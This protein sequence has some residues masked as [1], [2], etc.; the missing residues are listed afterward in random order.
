MRTVTSLTAVLLGFIL[1]APA[2]V[3]EDAKPDSNDLEV[4]QLQQP[5]GPE[6]SPAQ[7]YCS[8]IM[9]T[10]TAA[11]I[12]QQTRNLEAAQKQLDDRIA[13]LTE[14]A[15]VLKS[16]IKLR[17]EFSARAT[18]YLVQMY[19]K[20]K[21]DAAAAQIAAMDEMIAA[22]VMS[23]LTPKVSGLIM[24]EMS[25]EKAARLSA[26]IAGAGEVAIEP[27]RRADAQQ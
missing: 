11:Q 12:A 1:C 8:S 16:W 20:M 14:K 23:K 13:V 25:A 17:E 21:P 6:L 19:T 7:Q 9:D 4:L 2:A 10:A 27:E 5:K 22:A 18:D 26:V 24:T 15:E 3:A